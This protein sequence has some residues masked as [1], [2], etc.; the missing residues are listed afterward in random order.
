MN[1]LILGTCLLLGAAAA[2]T[3]TVTPAQSGDA[4]P[5]VAVTDFRNDTSAGWWGSGV[6]RELSTMLSNEM[7]ATGQFRMVD[8]ANL[9]RTLQEQ[10]LAASGR[11]RQGTGARTGQIT[12]AQY[13]VQGTVTSYSENTSKT[14]GGISVKG[15]S[16]GG[17]RKEAYIAIDL[18]VVD[19]ET[20]EI[21]YTRTVEGRSSGGG[22][23]V[24]VFRGGFGGNLAHE[25]N[26]PAGK[27][28]R[29]ALVEATDYLACVMVERGA[30][31]NEYNAR[32]SRRRA[33]NRK[34]IKLD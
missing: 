21:A 20:G 30:C 5:V 25:N 1:R 18:Q 4:R 33:G 3:P 24:G 23:S 32:E 9:G 16:L 15:I 34:A 27:A 10:D 31:L 13:L 17:K 29:A 28:I 6:G 22:V 8:R 7:N 26:T 11:V 2:F 19:S 14:G 12:G